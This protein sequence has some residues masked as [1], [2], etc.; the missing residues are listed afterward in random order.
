MYALYAGIAAWTIE[1]AV[2]GI[3]LYI[4]YREEQKVYKRRKKEPKDE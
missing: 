3:I 4:L 2:A 1:L